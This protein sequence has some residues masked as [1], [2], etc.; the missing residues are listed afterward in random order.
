MY[1]IVYCIHIVIGFANHSYFR[2]EEGIVLNISKPQQHAV[3]QMYFH[4]LNRSSVNWSRPINDAS[5][6]RH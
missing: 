2:Q 5:F 1:L 4:D 6:K 3:Q